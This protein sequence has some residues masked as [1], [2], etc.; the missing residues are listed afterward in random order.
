MTEMY[1]IFGLV[2]FLGSIAWFMERDEAIKRQWYE[3]MKID[4]LQTS[5]TMR[6]LTRNECERLIDSF[7]GR[8]SGLI[9]EWELSNRTAAL[10]KRVIEAQR[11]REE[12]LKRQERWNR[13]Q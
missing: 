1:L 9:D 10:Y 3:D 6:H 4:H 2:V 7:Y 5:E 11:Q 13:N 8:W 12:M